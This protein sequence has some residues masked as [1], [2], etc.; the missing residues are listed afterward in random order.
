MLT[1]NMIKPE[2]LNHI[3]FEFYKECNEESLVKL[4]LRADQL[5]NARQQAIKILKT[6]IEI[7][8]II[9][10]GSMVWSLL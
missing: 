4:L 3:F 2:I 5:H 6:V 10:P 7:D 1:D 8:L 9:K